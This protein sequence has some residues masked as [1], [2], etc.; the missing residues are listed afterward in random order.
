LP[1]DADDVRPSTAGT[2][3]KIRKV[4]NQYIYWT[5]RDNA[6]VASTRVRVANEQESM[7]R[8]F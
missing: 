7:Y 1:E 8:F 6:V 2:E 5:I 4:W 3:R